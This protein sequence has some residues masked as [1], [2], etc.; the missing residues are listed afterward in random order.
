MSSRSLGNGRDY[1]FELGGDH[2]AALVMRHPTSLED[3]NMIAEFKS[4]TK[5]HYK[6]WIEFAHGKG[7]QGRDVHPF[8]VSSF[9]MTTD[10]SVVA[11]PNEDG[12]SSADNT[13]FLSGPLSP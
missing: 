9:N 8:L 11:Y 5:H 10:F 6:S 4:Y 12:I 1:V 13:P 2:G 3:T 7:H